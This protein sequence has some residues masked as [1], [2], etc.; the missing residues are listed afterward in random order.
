M[1]ID[2][3]FDQEISREIADSERNHDYGAEN[4]ETESE[5]NPEDCQRQSLILRCSLRQPLFE[6]FQ[7]GGFARAKID[8]F[9]FERILRHLFQS[10]D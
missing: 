8:L 7:H 2:L 10:I 4:R 1:A 3:S 5:R 9:L 6:K